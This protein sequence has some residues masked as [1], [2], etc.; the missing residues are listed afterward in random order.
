MCVSG[1]LLSYIIS[2]LNLA[3][4]WVAVVQVFILLHL[5]GVWHRH[6]PIY[7]SATGERQ[8][9]SFG[10]WFSLIPCGSWGP[11]S[12]GRKPFVAPDHVGR[13]EVVIHECVWT[14]FDKS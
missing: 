3:V 8:K 1:W 2:I 6:V 13:P 9:T 14:L 4:L 10:S 12:L 5:F 7:V 11:V